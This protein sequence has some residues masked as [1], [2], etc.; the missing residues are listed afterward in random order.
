M[1]M[2]SNLINSNCTNS[3]SDNP[4]FRTLKSKLST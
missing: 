4:D 3:D 2:P 1:K